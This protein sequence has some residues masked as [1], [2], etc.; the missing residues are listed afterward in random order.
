MN[1]TNPKPVDPLAPVQ[2][3][4]RDPIAQWL[5]V[6]TRLLGL[7]GAERQSIRDELEDHL[8]NRVDD[9]M[10][11]GMTEYE[12]V[13][14]AVAELGET[15]DLAKR[16]KAARTSPHRRY[17]M[18]TAIAA[19]AGLAL[20]L[21]VF[22]MSSRPSPAAAPGLSGT[23]SAVRPDDNEYLASDPR[24]DFDIPDGT[25]ASTL[26]LLGAS[27]KVPV[28]IHWND[29]TASDHAPDDEVIAIP[30]KGLK[31]SRILQIINDSIPHGAFA[32]VAFGWDPIAMISDGNLTEIATQSYFDDR[33]R[34][35]VQH[36]IADFIASRPERERNEKVDEIIATIESVVE[37][38]TWSENGDSYPIIIYG[39]HLLID[40][41][42]RMQDEVAEMLDRLRLIEQEQAAAEAAAKAEH[43]AQLRERIDQLISQRSELS[44]QTMVLQHELGGL[45]IVESD[46]SDEEREGQFG[47]WIELKVELG[48]IED[49]RRFIQ[50]QID[51]ARESLS[52][53]SIAD[54]DEPGAD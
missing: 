32:H 14:R 20:T 31:R 21:G 44:K 25:L 5:D 10:I 9:L 51:H 11:L 50:S 37:S 15:A 2:P 52:G 3:S 45:S 49:E 46:L 16:F 36:N 27:A 34:V 29:L 53:Y 43:D 38:D 22:S 54:Q 30:A 47:R 39:S 35:L 48:N 19:V 17:L 41:P 23:I 26:E 8:R 4:A 18:T 40:A 6:F 24:L 33:D 28:Y 12:A 13:Q 42:Q 7:P 1:K